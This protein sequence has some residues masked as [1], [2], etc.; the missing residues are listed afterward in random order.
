MVDVNKCL[1]FHLVPEVKSEVAPR[2]KMNFIVS[3][4]TGENFML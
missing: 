2:L 4:N 1:C 3:N